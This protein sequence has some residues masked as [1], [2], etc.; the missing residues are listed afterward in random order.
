MGFRGLPSTFTP[1][2]APSLCAPSRPLSKPSLSVT[3]LNASQLGL[4]QDTTT[5]PVTLCLLEPEW[6]TGI[7]RDL[8]MSVTW[9]FHVYTVG[10]SEDFSGI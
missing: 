1:G 2:N 9:T 8:H 5:R 7:P 10:N 6:G 3:T 4:T